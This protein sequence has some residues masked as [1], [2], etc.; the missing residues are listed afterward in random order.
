ML[1]RNLR[2]LAMLAV[3][4]PGPVLLVIALLSVALAKNIAHLQMRTDLVDLVSGATYAGKL[5]R[6][7]IRNLGYGNQ[8]FVVLEGGSTEADAETMEEAADRLTEDMR[9]SGHFQNVRFGMDADESMDMVRLYAWNFPAFADPSARERIARRLSPEGVKERVR[10]GVAGLVT[11]LGSMSASYFAVDP[12][13]LAELLAPQALATGGLMNFDME[14]GSGGRFFSRDHR[15]LLLIST[16]RLPASDYEFSV[17][18][19]G[20]MRERLA[21][22]SLD[23]RLAGKIRAVPVGA[24][25]Y[26]EQNRRLIQQNMRT[27]SLISVLGNLLLVLFV[28]RWIPAIVLTVLPTGLA[29][30]WTSGAVALYPGVVNLV[31]LSFIAILA[32]LG[33][34]QVTYFFSRV[35]EERARGA[36]LEDALTTTF[37][38]TGKSV[39]FCVLTTS[40][41]TLALALARFPPLAELGLILTVGL[42]MLAVHTLVTVPALLSLWWRWFPTG[43]SGSPFRFLPW[44]ADRVGLLVAARPRTVLATLLAVMV[45]A[46]AG[47]PALRLTAGGT[48]AFE[49]AD[50]LGVT[51]QRLLSE[52]FGLEGAPTVFLLEGSLASVL[53]RAERVESRLRGLRE[54]GALRSVVSPSSFLPSEATQAARRAALNGVDPQRIAAALTAALDE[55]HL[56][57]AP[58]AS[59]L[60]R[61]R[62]WRGQPLTLAEV[63]RRL[64]KGLLDNVITEVAPGVYLAAV[65][66]YSSNP[67]ATA[68]VPAATLAALEQEAGPVV[69]FSY[70]RIGQDLQDRLVVDSRLALAGTLAGVVSIVLIGFRRL[71][72]T[73]IVLAPIGFG[74]IVA[75][76]LLALA[77]HRFSAMA[78]SSIPLIIGIGI[79]NG[80]HLVRRYLEREDG[81]VHAVVAAS[82]P[83]VIQTN[84]TTIVGFGALTSSSFRPLAEMGLITAL[85]VGCT[86]VASL[87]LLPALLATT[88]RSRRVTP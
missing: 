71:K 17:G 87:S 15:A 50:A 34:D 80:I 78:F 81:D 52:R 14:W 38:T 26:S 69:E 44:V 75:F 68:A 6:E 43:V 11:P 86:L 4:H 70:D 64:P 10:S 9:Q 39:L 18:L 84:L 16:P 67:V 51:G 42:L 88:A 56:S 13:G 36:V 28:Y 48:D 32:G 2:R 33:D 72:P 25:V 7:A 63:R 74:V 66:V 22:L 65:T 73:L 8:F 30:L 85:G 46:S 47:L 3:R 59:L 62:E 24:H 35:P 1:D 21:A 76:G 49:G 57:P 61:I 58:F 60:E 79:D 31:S 29:L 19:M 53:S 27:A 54:T 41:G 77:R 82:G 55:N 20:W 5:Q 40:T 83:A 37:L 45:T 23:G 12:L